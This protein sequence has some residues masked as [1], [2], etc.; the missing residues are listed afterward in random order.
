ME[1][2]LRSRRLAIDQARAALGSA[3]PLGP[4]SSAAL[5]VDPR[6]QASWHRSAPVPRSLDAAPVEPMDEV[7]HRWDASPLRRA[8]P[9]IAD[10]LEQVADTGDLVV[11][12]TDADGRVLWQAMPRWLRPLA[13]RTG[14]VT[15]GLWQ[16]TTA[17]TNGIGL[18]LASDRPAAVFA[19]E[20][21]IESVRDWVCYSAPVHDAQRR[22]VGALDL[23]TEWSHANP[24]AL[25]TVSTLARMLEQAVLADE[26]SSAP[27]KRPSLDL[28][29]LGAPQ[30]RLD[31]APVRFTLRQVEIVT[32]LA[33]VGAVALGELHALLYGDRPVSIATLKAEMSRLRRV[34][35]G[36]LESRPYRLT[37]G[38]RVDAIELQH[39]LDRQDVEGA[40]EVYVGQLL[41]ASESP[42]LIDQ[43]HQVD[44]ALR[45]ALLRWGAP[46][47][48]L[49]YAKVHP[50]DLEVLEGACTR[51]APD[52]PLVPALTARL[53]IAG[54]V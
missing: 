43:R 24:L 23:S 13:D 11:A 27:A 14:F 49:R 34:L 31:G 44:V 40:A 20:H 36:R 1:T 48:V 38:C 37:L 3:S 41:P 28:R 46:A 45:T 17:G 29:V 8:L 32:I 15:G 42:F 52:H 50:Y 33:I 16:E 18:A 5:A 26:D 25:P 30:A 12:L 21:H 19:S 6:I 54:G 22:Q 2:E 39:R 7:A 35:G 53:A 10:Q 9:A 4:A 51:L 47:S